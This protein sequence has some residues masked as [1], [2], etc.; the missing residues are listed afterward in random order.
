MLGQGM[1]TRIVAILMICFVA[2]S[3]ATAVSSGVSYT[4]FDSMNENNVTEVSVN[5][6]PTVSN[7]KQRRQYR[8]AYVSWI[9]RVF[10]RR[11]AYGLNW[12]R[13]HGGFTKVS[14]ESLRKW[15]GLD[16]I[17]NAIDTSV[18]SSK[19][20]SSSWRDLEITP[21]LNPRV[22]ISRRMNYV[23]DSMTMECELCGD[24]AHGMIDGLVAICF[25]S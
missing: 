15:L 19:S 4:S 24:D 8:L 10:S 7:S 12:A 13:G 21:T 23:R 1:Q 22:G 2:L 20:L 16:V 25:R 3:G 18:R 14:G 17:V 11:F 5:P 9:N 6:V